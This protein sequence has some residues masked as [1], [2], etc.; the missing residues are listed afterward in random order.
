[1]TQN[2]HHNYE[3][4]L[5][6]NSYL[7]NLGELDSVGKK[8]I[9]EEIFVFLSYDITDSTKLKA[10]FP[11]EWANAI[12][13]LLEAI[14][15]VQFMD[16]WKFNGDEIL[17]KCNIGSVDFLCKLIERSYKQLESLQDAM[18]KHIKCLTLKGTLW[19]AL[20][21]IDLTNYHSNYR[22]LVKE[23][24]DFSGKNIDEG[25]RLTKCSSMKKLAIDPKIVYILLEK[26]LELE[27]VN[28]DDECVDEKRALERSIK[29]ILNR[30]YYIGDA[31]CKGIW[32]NKPYPIY[33]FYEVDASSGIRYGEFLNGIHLWREEHISL[34][35][36][37]NNEIR[38]MKRMFQQVDAMNEVE[39]IIKRLQLFG[40][41]NRSSAG[42]ANLYFMVVCINP[43]TGSV[44][45]AQRSS[46]RK[47]L[48]GVWDFGNVKYQKIAME[49]VIKSKYKGTFGIDIDILKDFD[50][51]NSLKPFS[52]CTIY[53]NNMP[54]NGIMLYALIKTN[55]QMSDIELANQIT[56]KIKA[57]YL[58]Q[59]V[60]FVDQNE[61]GNIF[62]RY[63]ELTLSEICLDSQTAP[64]NTDYSDKNVGIM[65]FYASIK[66]AIEVW[67]NLSKEWLKNG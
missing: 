9:Q 12:S 38:S 21:T 61:I 42:K 62:S 26:A 37:I 45:I 8:N 18:Q 36:A 3:K 63:T 28:D 20:T 56:E 58:Y 24:V 67:N 44:L 65:N 35:K 51:G 33:W 30:T 41:R 60:K 7:K 50:R 64:K 22:F 10:N 47:H 29:N 32:D 52:Y 1:M 66:D 53:R 34:Y 57:N 13:V 54:H 16:F 15:E 19:I 46:L 5:E 43:A 40:V 39:S 4:V 27:D 6:E 49:E 31:L 59:K 11:S 17:F 2:N 14:N 25:F 48:K 23:N 55:E